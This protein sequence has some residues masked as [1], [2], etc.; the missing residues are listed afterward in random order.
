VSRISWIHLFVVT[1]IA[2]VALLLI[3]LHDASGATLEESIAAGRRLTEIWCSKCH[4][5][6]TIVPGRPP[7]FTRIAN[8][9]TTESIKAFLHK[10]HA[11][12]PNSP[13]P[14]ARP[15]KSPSSS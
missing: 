9:S 2:L 15:T 14:R 4:A 6:S 3:R 12:M 13:F 5:V 7:D 1:V 10:D 11:R 8:V